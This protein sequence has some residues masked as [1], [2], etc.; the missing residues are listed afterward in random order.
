MRGVCER[1]DRVV[2]EADVPLVPA[3]LGDIQGLHVR[4]DDE[5][6]M[7]IRRPGHEL[8]HRAHGEPVP[9]AALGIVVEDAAVVGGGCVVVEQAQ[10]GEAAH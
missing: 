1:P 8:P 9:V 7:F 2:A 10:D 6:L 3:D 4:E 5:H